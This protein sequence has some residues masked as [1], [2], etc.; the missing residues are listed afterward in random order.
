MAKV[1][2]DRP[3]T[4]LKGGRAQAHDC[5]NARR[6]S[7]RD[8][9]RGGW[10]ANELVGRFRC[11][12]GGLQSPPPPATSL[13]PHLERA[14]A[15]ATAATARPIH[16][17]G[18]GRLGRLGSP[19]I[20]NKRVVEQNCPWCSGIAGL[21]AGSGASSMR[22]TLHLTKFA[23]FGRRC[24]AHAGT[25]NWFSAARGLR[26]AAGVWRCVDA[27]LTPTTGDPHVSRSRM[28]AWPLASP[29]RQKP[30]AVRCGLLATLPAQSVRVSTTGHQG[31]QYLLQG[32]RTYLEQPL[33][34]G[35]MPPAYPGGRA[36]CR[37]DLK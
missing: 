1:K 23:N 33:N 32:K 17:L 35:L 6:T 26:K 21:A 27:P 3:K 16:R 2:P 29:L 19:L 15:I 37:N 30:L 20:A 14:G 11:G 5:T 10:P 25:R 8:A 9:V 7:G 18:A 28:S 13:P 34:K 12:S 24:P 22:D 31:S 36:R 4:R